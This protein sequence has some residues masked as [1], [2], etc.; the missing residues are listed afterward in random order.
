MPDYGTTAEFKLAFSERQEYETTP[1]EERK[2]HKNLVG[3][4]KHRYPER[5][6]DKIKIRSTLYLAG[7]RAAIFWQRIEEGMPLS[8]ASNLFLVCETMWTAKSKREQASM[9]FDDVVRERL[10]RYDAQGNVRS[11]NG[12]TWR[13]STPI[14]RAA[15]VA[16]GEEKAAIK[17]PG[18]VASTQHKTVVREAIAAWAAAR[19]PKNDPRAA[20]W[21]ADLMR[22]VE[23]VL[24]SFA[25]RIK[26]DKPS[27]DELFAACS[28]LNIP[29]PRWGQ[30]AD[31]K[32]AW[33]NRRAVLRANH[34]DALG[35][36]GGR[37]AYQAASD[38]YDVIA[39]YNDSLNPNP[40]MTGEPD[41]PSAS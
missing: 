20:T 41:V 40:N 8:T 39:A 13:T 5:S 17:D 22:E 38:A 16:K 1:L 4:I 30:P 21:A 34:P 35:H 2:K 6:T 14:A 28:L 33:R 32:R 24:S 7:S 15:R 9:A 29:R 11:K 36:D 25:S 10:A 23:V 3:F 12:K 18:D 27:R 26:M 31:I 19:L 37:D